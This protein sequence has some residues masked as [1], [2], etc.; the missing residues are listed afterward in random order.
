MTNV[1]I[2]YYSRT[3]TTRQ[4]AQQ[5]QQL[6]GWSIG[7]V[8][9]VRPRAGLRGDLRCVVESLLARSAPHAYEGPE[10]ARFDRLVV[11]TPIW[12]GR[13]ASPMRAFL[14]LLYANGATRPT[15]E[16]SLVCVMSRRGAFNAADEVA[17]I[18]GS[19]PMPVLALREADVLSGNILAPLQSLA[20]TVGTLESD[21]AVTRPIWLSPK[22]A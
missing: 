1:L 10:V 22:A 19:A 8:R 21:K 12:V 15:C 11:L 17:T 6:T 5:L 13:L 4:A 18:V 3:G 16:I 7:E 20:D 2:S 14:R 9:D